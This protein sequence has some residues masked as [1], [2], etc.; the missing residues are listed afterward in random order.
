MTSTS[1]KTVLAVLGGVSILWIAWLRQAGA[2]GSSPAP[3]AARRATPT[4]EATAAIEER[5]PAKG[6]VLHGR[7][8][9]ESGRPVAGAEIVHF[10]LRT[11]TDDYHVELGSFVRATS[12]A[13][14]TFQVAALPSGPTSLEVRARGFVPEQRRVFAGERVTE[15]RV[16]LVRAAP[17]AGRVVGAPADAE[18]GVSFRLRVAS[19]ERLVRGADDGSVVIDGLSRTF[20]PF[21]L[22]AVR[23]RPGASGIPDPLA[24]K[25][26]ERISPAVSVQPGTREFE[27]RVSP[28]STFRLQVV[29]ALTRQPLSEAHIGLLEGCVAESDRAPEVLPEGAGV[30]TLRAHLSES[31]RA[32]T[33]SR[34]HARSGRRSRG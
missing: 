5:A 12:A 34:A 7:V 10:G 29:D 11:L 3:S 22:H 20:W 13:D 2:G 17:V 24:P 26:W 9:D 32:V 16:V 15:W 18:P 14:G 23:K 33:V 1:S 31:P 28:L 30:H 6:A 21:D 4:A 19:A 8:V 25:D 27:I